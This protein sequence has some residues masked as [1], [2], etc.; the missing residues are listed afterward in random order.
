MTYSPSSMQNLSLK[1]S[2]IILLISGK[3]YNKIE[4]E[5]IILCYEKYNSF[6][7]ELTIV[8]CEIIGTFSKLDEPNLNCM[9]HIIKYLKVLF[10]FYI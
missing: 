7:N 8:D 3:Q 5:K 10:W 6:I 1:R 2:Q 4:Y 9:F